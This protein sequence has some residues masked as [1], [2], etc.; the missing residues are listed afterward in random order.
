MKSQVILLALSLLSVF[1]SNSYVIVKNKSG[2]PIDIKINYADS[3][4]AG[5]TKSDA[6]SLD[7]EATLY[8]KSPNDN[9][10]S[11]IKQAIPLKFHVNFRP[12]E[13]GKVHPTLM[14]II[15]STV[16]IQQDTRVITVWGLDSID[17][18]SE[19]PF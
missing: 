2:Y 6:C 17:Q 15:Q 9:R 8:C 5:N 10:N 12:Y 18:S 11:G 7:K 19:L 16:D 4:W 13:P 3:Y 14:A 1:T